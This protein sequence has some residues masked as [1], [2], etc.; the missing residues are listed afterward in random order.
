MAPT[1]TVNQGWV[2]SSVAEHLP[3]MQVLSFNPSTG[4]KTNR[5]N[6]SKLKAMLYTFWRRRW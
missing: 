3:N 6:N 5:K 2:Y 1:K 4:K